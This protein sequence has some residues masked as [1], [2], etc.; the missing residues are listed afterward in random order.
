MESEGKKKCVRLHIQPRKKKKK[1]GGC[2]NVLLQWRWRAQ[3]DAGSASCFMPRSAERDG[4]AHPPSSASINMNVRRGYQTGTYLSLTWLF[5]PT[6]TVCFNIIRRARSRTG[7][8]ALAQRRGCYC[9]LNIWW[10]LLIMNVF[11]KPYT[12]Y[13]L[14][15]I[16]WIKSKTAG[17]TWW[18][19]VF[20]KVVSH[21][22]EKVKYAGKPCLSTTPANASANL[23]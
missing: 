21:A 22:G 9:N 16:P 17:V 23:S 15:Y 1:P 11:L 3:G 2:E 14:I 20:L 10:S 5:T 6:S 12:L 19:W 4:D 18:S 7:E 8:E 13:V